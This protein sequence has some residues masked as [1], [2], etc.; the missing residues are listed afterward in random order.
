ML[1]L[2]FFE[3]LADE[4]E[5]S[6]SLCMGQW[7]GETKIAGGWRR[8]DEA[9]LIYRWLSLRSSGQRMEK[10]NRRPL[11]AMRASKVI[12]GVFLQG[13]SASSNVG[14]KWEVK[15]RQ[16][17]WALEPSASLLA[18][19][20]NEQPASRLSANQR[21]STRVHADNKRWWW[22]LYFSEG[23]NWSRFESWHLVG[24]TMSFQ[25]VTTHGGCRRPSKVEC[26]HFFQVVWMTFHPSLFIS[27]VCCPLRF[28]QRTMCNEWAGGGRISLS[29]GSR[30]RGIFIK[31]ARI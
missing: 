28:Q 13:R 1:L 8:E 3:L 23:P 10:R 24:K 21:G 27:T 5:S 20:P 30:S 6:E 29:F 2:L 17:P 11:N 26:L 9:A 19:L 18:D 15:S 25:S 14:K 12:L 7:M 4:S 22:V 16:V 31:T